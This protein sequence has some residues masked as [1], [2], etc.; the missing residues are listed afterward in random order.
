VGGR[1]WDIRFFLQFMLAIYSVIHVEGKER[2]RQDE[3][4]F[5]AGTVLC[6]VHCWCFTGVAKIEK[7]GDNY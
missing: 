6:T 5:V 4:F 2:R 1:S 3:I 7:F